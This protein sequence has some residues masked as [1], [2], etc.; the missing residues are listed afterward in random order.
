MRPQFQEILKKG[1]DIVKSLAAAFPDDLEVANSIDSLLCM[2][3]RHIARK[4]KFPAG[5]SAG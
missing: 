2:R 3:G 1:N 5:T 4:G